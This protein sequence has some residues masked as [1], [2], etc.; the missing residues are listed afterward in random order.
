LSNVVFTP[1]NA[2]QAE[3][4]WPRIVRACFA[5]IERVARGEPPHFLARKLE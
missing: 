3:E 2:G 5:N 1:H 4:V